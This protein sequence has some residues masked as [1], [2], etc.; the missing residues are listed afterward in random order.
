MTICR[1]RC[2]DIRLAL[3]SDEQWITTA[4]FF[5]GKMGISAAFSSI[6]LMTGE[7]FPTFIRNGIVGAGSCMGRIASLLSPFIADLV[8]TPFVL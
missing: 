8:C 6:Y 3:L 5:I 7:L 2:D 1:Y 4:L